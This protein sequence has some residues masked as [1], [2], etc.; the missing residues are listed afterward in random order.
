MNLFCCFR[1]LGYVTLLLRS[2]FICVFAGIRIQWANKSAFENNRVFTII[3][4][5][6]LSAIAVIAVVLYVFVSRP[7]RDM[8]Y[9]VLKFIGSFSAFLGPFSLLMVIVLPPELNWIGY[10]V[11]CVMFGI[12]VTCFY[13]D[14]QQH[15]NKSSIINDL[16]LISVFFLTW[17][18]IVFLRPSLNWIMYPV[19]YVS[20]WMENAYHLITYLM[21]IY[22]K[23]R[24]HEAHQLIPQDENNNR[25]TPCLSYLMQLKS[26]SF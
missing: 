18:S 6:S 11:A 4:I 24:K 21:F 10:L 2:F 3:G 14:D 20:L 13:L 12:L 25:P 17:S 15:D 1:I 16:A 5:V 9:I 26:S 8:C 7:M 22:E 19:I 23:A